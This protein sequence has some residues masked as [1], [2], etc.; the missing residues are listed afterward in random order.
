MFYKIVERNIISPSF[1]KREETTVHFFLPGSA[2]FP[3]GRGG[4]GMPIFHN[5]LKQN[6]NINP[7]LKIFQ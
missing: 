2:P 4:D 7:Y 1:S 6:K 3:W 5:V